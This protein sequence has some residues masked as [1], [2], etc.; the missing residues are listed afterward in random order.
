LHFG[1]QLQTWDFHT[2]LADEGKVRGGRLSKHCGLGNSNFGSELRPS[3]VEVFSTR[4]GGNKE[5]RHEASDIDEAMIKL[6]III[7]KKLIIWRLLHNNN[8]T[9]LD[10]KSIEYVH[11]SGL[12]E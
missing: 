4:F 10:R 3:S 2:W 6:I 12:R 11:T 5:K 1:D 7:V 9:T 8:K